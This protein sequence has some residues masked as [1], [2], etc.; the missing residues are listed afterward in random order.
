VRPALP[1]RS[2]GVVDTTDQTY[3]RPALEPPQILAEDGPYPVRL[4]QGFTAGDPYRVAVAASLTPGHRLAS[5][6]AVLGNG[7]A[8]VGSITA[9]KISRNGALMAGLRRG[10]APFEER[11][12]VS[13]ITDEQSLRQLLAD[14]RLLYSDVAGHRFH[15][16][17]L[18]RDTAVEV[19]DHLRRVRATVEKLPAGRRSKARV[20]KHPLLGPAYRLAWYTHRL[21]HEQIDL[22]GRVLSWL[23]TAALYGNSVDKL[24]T[25]LERL[26]HPS[27]DVLHA[28]PDSSWGSGR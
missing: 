24:R 3:D 16:L 28:A 20:P 19:C 1:S 26:I 14:R 15:E 21:A 10:L 22:D 13:V 2:E 12:R 8:F 6:A 5:Y 25:R 7:N 23:G 9:T 4:G 27:A 18:Y 11:T 17:L